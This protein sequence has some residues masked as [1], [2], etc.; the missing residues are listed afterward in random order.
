[1]KRIFETAHAAHDGALE[2]GM[3]IAAASEAT[4][5]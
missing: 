1:M 4:H 3:L 2:H 5:V